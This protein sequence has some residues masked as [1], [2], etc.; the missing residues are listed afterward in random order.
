MKI[1]WTILLAILFG[2]ASADE[3]KLTAKQEKNWDITV[4]KP[5]EAESYPLGRIIAE[6]V[7]PPTLLHTISLPFEANV[8]KLYVA[9]YQRVKRGDI[10]AR[11]TGTRWIEAQQRAIEDAIEYRHHKHMTERKHMLCKEEIIPYKECKAADAE[12]E[13]DKIRL[14]SSKALLESYGANRSMIE[15]IFKTLKISNAITVRSDVDGSI[16]TLH[17][18]PGKST[19]PSDALF[20]IK[21]RGAL[22]IEANIEALRTLKLTEGERVRFGMAGKIFESRVL[23]LSDVVDP[24]NQTRRVR[25]SVPENVLLA[26]GLILSADLI[27]FGK[28]LKLPKG[29]V[30]KEGGTQIAFLRTKFGFRAIPLEVLAEDETFYYIKPTAQLKGEVAV[31]SLAILKNLLG[32]NNE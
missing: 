15:K 5:Q 14:A 7:T 18:T 32:G 10:L 17:A 22:W 3:V 28:T 2:F 1:Q 8:L 29:A 16:I 12:L 27:I 24:K 13:A 31:N 9:K 20:V 21:Q 4:A 30:I 23:Q 11:V 6:V 25:F 19:T 26:S